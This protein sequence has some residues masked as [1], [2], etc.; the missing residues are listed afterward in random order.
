MRNKVE[1]DR[2]RRG[3]SSKQLRTNQLPRASKRPMYISPLLNSTTVDTFLQPSAS[4]SPRALGWVVQNHEDAYKGCGNFHE[5]TAY[6][7][8]YTGT[9]ICFDPVKNVTSYLLT[10]R[11]YDDHDANSVEIKFVSIFLH[12][13][14]NVA[15]LRAF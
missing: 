4:Y 1:L 15:S 14:P 3:D 7:T 13:L 2:N 8:G 12:I 9:L 11:V 10:S 6:H 5:K